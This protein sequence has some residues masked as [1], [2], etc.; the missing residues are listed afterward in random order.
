MW[1]SYSQ[2]NQC[3]VCSTVSSRHVT[4]FFVL[5][6]P[7]PA[8]EARTNLGDL[9]LNDLTAEELLTD[10]NHFHCQRCTTMVTGRRHAVIQ[11]PPAIL[12]LHLQRFSVSPDHESIKKMNQVD[13]D[14]FIT[15][16]CSDNQDP[17]YYLYS[18]I[19]HA[20]LSSDHGHYFSIC[21]C[22]G[23]A[24]C[25]G[26][27]PGVGP[28]VE[29]PEWQIFDDSF[30][31]QLQTLSACMNDVKEMYQ[32]T[33][34]P[35]IVCYSRGSS[36]PCPICTARSSGILDLA[37]QALSSPL[38]SFE[39][40]AQPHGMISSSTS[41]PPLP[42][43]HSSIPPSTPR[44]LR[45]GLASVSAPVNGSLREAGKSPTLKQRVLED[46]RQ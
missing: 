35:Y 23:C 18:I 14:P 36:T 22:S 5:H 11:S 15:L 37:R 34:T 8:A 17:S 43:M 27:S 13:I 4:P 45:P 2:S 40:V 32:H 21:R 26:P 20:G 29:Q 42:A 41:T 46:L 25:G 6:V 12:V 16:Y 30:V 33:A 24:A 10:D 9:L 3:I 1:G 38:T 28:V 39:E 19:M 44:L 31:S 7:L